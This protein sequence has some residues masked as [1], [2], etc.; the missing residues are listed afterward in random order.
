VRLGESCEARARKGLYEKA[1][2]GLILESTDISDPYEFP[3]SD[4][5]PPQ[6]GRGPQEIFL[7]LLRGL[8]D[9]NPLT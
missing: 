8:G 9:L 2:K 4:S 1:C 3:R 7:V 5:T 6:P